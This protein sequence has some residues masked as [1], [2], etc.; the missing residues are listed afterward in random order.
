MKKAH[1]CIAASLVCANLH[2]QTNHIVHL[3]SVIPQGEFA[4]LINLRPGNDEVTETPLGDLVIQVSSGRFIVSKDSVWLSEISLK[5]ELYALAVK[6]GTYKPINFSE[7]SPRGKTVLERQIHLQRPRCEIAES[8]AFF[9][10]AM[11]N[12][13]IVA[14]NFVYAISEAP[15]LFVDRNTGRDNTATLDA[16][17][18]KY[19]LKV[20]RNQKEA[21]EMRKNLPWTG[22]AILYNFVFPIQSRLQLERRGNEIFEPWL[23]NKHRELDRQIK[24]TFATGD[25]WQ[26]LV[27]GS[28]AKTFEELMALNNNKYQ[29][30]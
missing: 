28:D 20:V 11:V 10:E 27:K 3:P 25:A 12:T 7:L 9:L 16:E 23:M 13:Q 1:Y 19:S 30:L 26:D 4:R 29:S 15:N 2:S 21:E 5:K 22:E 24:E 6:H 14:T 17:M 18:S 8:S